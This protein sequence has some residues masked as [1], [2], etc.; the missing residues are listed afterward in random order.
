MCNWILQ[1]DKN[2]PNAT[3]TLSSLE[4]VQKTCRESGA[5]NK[6]F[7]KLSSEALNC[8]FVILLG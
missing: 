3:K 8:F 5:L 1:V 7:A 2:D 4:A 6:R